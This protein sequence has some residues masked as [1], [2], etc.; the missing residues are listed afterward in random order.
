MEIGHV[1]QQGESQQNQVVFL[2]SQ[3]GVAVPVSS[4]KPA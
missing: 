3:F 1:I 2:R 4:Q